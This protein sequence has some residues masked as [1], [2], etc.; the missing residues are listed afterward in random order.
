MSYKLSDKRKIQI[1]R[2]CINF[3]CNTSETFKMHM[4]PNSIRIFNQMDD[5]Q[6]TYML[7]LYANW[8]N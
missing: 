2:K 3:I 4:T 7:D 8:W 6:S 1:F 5:D